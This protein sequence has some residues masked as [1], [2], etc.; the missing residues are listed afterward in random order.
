[1]GKTDEESAP[2]IGRRIVAK[3]LLSV[4]VEVAHGKIILP[5]NCVIFKALLCVCPVNVAVSPVGSG[6]CWLNFGRLS[7]FF[8][9][10]PRVFGGRLMRV[11]GFHSK[12]TFE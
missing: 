9:L 1:M 8:F 11:V 12:S 3:C 5:V 6:F 10:A 2:S 4:S 7:F